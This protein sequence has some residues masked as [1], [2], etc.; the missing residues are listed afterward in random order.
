MN[1]VYLSI[2]MANAACLIHWITEQEPHISRKNG[3]LSIVI[4]VMNYLESLDT[5]LVERYPLSQSALTTDV[6]LDNRLAQIS[7]FKLVSGTRPH[8]AIIVLPKP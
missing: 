5:D 1:I 2:L 4:A 8:L 7:M 6:S 3:A